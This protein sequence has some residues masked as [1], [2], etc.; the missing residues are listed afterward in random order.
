MDGGVDIS[1]GRTSGPKEKLQPC[2]ADLIDRHASV[3]TI[4]TSDDGE[5]K[6]D[7]SIECALK[8]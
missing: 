4:D 1:G 3:P 5:Q 6:L 8:C 2:T 7:E